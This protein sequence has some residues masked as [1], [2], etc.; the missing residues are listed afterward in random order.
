MVNSVVNWFLCNPYWMHQIILI[1]LYTWYF[2]KLHFA[3][4]SFRTR[5]LI[6]LIAAVRTG[7]CY[8]PCRDWEIEAVRQFGHTEFDLIW[9]QACLV[10]CVCLFR[11]YDAHTRKLPRD[12]SNQPTVNVTCPSTG[13]YG[14]IPGTNQY[15][16]GVRPLPQSP[17]A[18]PFVPGWPPSLPDRNVGSY[19]FMLLMLLLFWEH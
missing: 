10:F 18:Q 13:D 7:L 11:M 9:N 19:Y 15:K 5:K 3:V 4:Y 12:G 14:S 6:N 2:F 1:V 16:N 17:A 8:C